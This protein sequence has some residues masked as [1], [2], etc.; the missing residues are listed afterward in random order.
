MLSLTQFYS[1]LMYACEGGHKEM[2]ELLLDHGARVDY[3]G[4]Q[5]YMSRD[6]GRVSY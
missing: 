3:V 2:V 4:R 5:F 1:P 6:R